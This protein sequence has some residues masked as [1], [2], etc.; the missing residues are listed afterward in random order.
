MKICKTTLFI[1]IFAL[2]TI[3]FA[4]PIQLDKGDHLEHIRITT[5]QKYNGEIGYNSKTNVQ[6]KWGK[7]IAVNNDV[8]MMASGEQ[9]I[10]WGDKGIKAIEIPKIGDLI[11]NIQ[12]TSGNNLIYWSQ[13]LS[14][15][16]LNSYDPSTKNVLFSHRINVPKHFEENAISC[17][18][19]T[20]AVSASHQLI[21]L[22]LQGDGYS[23]SIKKNKGFYLILSKF[24][25]R[26]FYNTNH[27]E[28]YI[29]KYI[30]KRDDEWSEPFILPHSIFPQLNKDEY[31][32]EPTALA[33]NG[34]TI[35][36]QTN[37]DRLA[38]IHEKNG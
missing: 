25:N 5:I 29:V 34:K 24:G 33:N 1:N 30:D 6:A 38:L 26:L 4:Q 13:S 20:I 12:F 35:V 18:G 27:E 9:L 11:T 22:T 36:V 8:S 21:L 14:D 28:K 37:N 10:K 7:D 23:R 15:Y 16:Y 3:L 32:V 17:D 19:K 31:W 2:P